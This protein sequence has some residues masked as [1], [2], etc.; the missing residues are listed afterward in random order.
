MRLFR[1]CSYI[2]ET[3]S[4]NNHVTPRCSSPRYPGFTG[5]DFFTRFK[6]T[7]CS[8]NVCSTHL[9]INNGE[10]YAG[11]VSMAKPCSA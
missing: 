5:G 10:R 4:Q 8:I 7:T 3:H 6:E 2:M 1:C 9:A 11:F